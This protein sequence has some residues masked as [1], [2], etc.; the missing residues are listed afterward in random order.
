MAKDLQHGY[1]AVAVEAAAEKNE[2]EVDS[3]TDLFMQR[4]ISHEGY[5]PCGSFV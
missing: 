2:R 1:L 4:L 3:V 5:A